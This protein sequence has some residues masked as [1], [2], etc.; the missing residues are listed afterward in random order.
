MRWMGYARKVENQSAGRSVLRVEAA[1]EEI[2]WF[3]QE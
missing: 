3:E 1:L 2:A